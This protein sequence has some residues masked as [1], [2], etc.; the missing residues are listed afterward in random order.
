M[1]KALDD[2]IS[3]LDL[4]ELEINLFR[5]RSPREERQRVFGGQVAGQALVAACRTIEK[6]L[7]HSLHAYFIRPGDP[8]V[9]IIY[10]VDRIRDGRSFVTRRVTAIQHGEAIFALSA[11]FQVPEQG[12]EHQDPM[13]NA[14]DPETLPSFEERA[15][16]LRA[17][18][19]PEMRA[20]LDRDRPIET[21]SVDGSDLPTHEKREPHSLVWLRAKGELPD[22]QALHQCVV[23]YA[24]DMTL[25][26]TA[27]RPHPVYSA[28]QRVQVTSLDHAMWFHR[29]FRADEWLLYEQQSPSMSGA[30]GFTTGR[31]FTRDG[32]LVVSVAQEG[33][34]RLLRNTAR[35]R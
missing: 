22:D 24:S 15:A 6:Q 1:Q 13:P 20:W 14:P 17:L 9:P 27:A 11:S 3:M 18:A 29:P 8:T 26:D 32:R 33:L 12:F 5:G 4:E 34:F 7:V 31:F 10:Q 19:A 16:A 25:L 35:G 21:R 30:R 28:E 2:L 23:A